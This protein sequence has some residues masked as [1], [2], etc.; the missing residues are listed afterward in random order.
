[1]LL[2]SQGKIIEKYRVFCEGL[3]NYVEVPDFWLVHGG[4]DTR[5]ENPFIHHQ[6]M[7]ELRRFEYDTTKLKNKRV[8]HGHQVHHLSAIQQAIEKQA[9]IIP[10]DNGCVYTKPHKV[11]D[12]QQ[13]GQLCCL[14]LDT[15]ELI[16]QPNIDD[17]TK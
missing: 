15:W 1:M 6:A 10:L 4:F 13:L 9:M 12:F 11:H 17:N 5:Q 16:T 2:D 8:V 3:V 14:N 7:L